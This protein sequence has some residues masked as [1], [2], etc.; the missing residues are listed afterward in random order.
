MTKINLFAFTTVAVLSIGIGSYFALQKNPSDEIEATAINKDIKYIPAN[1]TNDTLLKEIDPLDEFNKLPFSFKYDGKTY[2]VIATGH[3][4]RDY[5]TF[6]VDEYEYEN[7][8]LDK[9][10]KDTTLISFDNEDKTI[11]TNGVP[12]KLIRK[13]D[14]DVSLKVFANTKVYIIPMN[15]YLDFIRFSDVKKLSNKK[16]N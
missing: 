6:I 3:V 16:S 12:G 2:N 4:D 8:K 7:K 1:I 11:I 10:L 5:S 13:A 14:D 9:I 15:T